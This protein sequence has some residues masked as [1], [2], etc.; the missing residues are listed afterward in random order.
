MRRPRNRRSRFGPNADDVTALLEQ[1]ERLSMAE[2][3][4]L[5]AAGEALGSDRGPAEPPR[6]EPDPRLAEARTRL[7]RLAEAHDRTGA[8]RAVGDEIADW[9]ASL[10]HWF[11]AGIA[12]GSEARSEISPRMAALPAVL[13]AAY[14]TVMED[15]LTEDDADLLC[16]AWDDVVP[17]VDDQP[18]VDVE[19]Q[20]MADGDTPGKG[21]PR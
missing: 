1:L 13:D 4:G 10:A 9:A 7:R 17:D 15:L 11:P 5:A 18:A 19:G 8:L 2:V 6:S 16:A 20:P 21:P 3:L 12:G 14:A